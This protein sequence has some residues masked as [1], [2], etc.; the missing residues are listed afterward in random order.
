MEKL[1]LIDAYARIVELERIVIKQGKDIDR[2][3]ME[4]D[5]LSVFVKTSLD[6]DHAIDQMMNEGGMDYSG[7]FE[8]DIDD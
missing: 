6:D 7:A 8:S 3:T 2:L 1:G 5:I 4:S